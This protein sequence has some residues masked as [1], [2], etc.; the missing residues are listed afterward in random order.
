MGRQ[1]TR[2]QVSGYRFTMRR[3]EHALVRGDVRML[4][5]PIRAQ[6]ISLMTG[7]VLA[8][9]AIAVCGVLAVLRPQGAPGD[10]PILRARESGA[11]YV[12]IGD[13]VHPVPDLVS[14]RL[15]VGSAADP[16]TVAAAAIEKMPRGP[17]A[18]IVGAPA[19]VGAPLAAAQ[20]EWTVCDTASATTLLIGPPAGPAAGEDAA[21]LV[22]ARSEGPAT[23]FLMYGGRRAAVDL[24]DTAV[25]RAL[26]LDTVAPHPVSRALLDTVPE[27]PPIIAPP[28]AGAGR[29]GALPGRPVGTIIGVRR[30][31]GVE[32]YVVLAGGLQ[33]VGEVT[34][35]LI[36]F[37]V[38]Q[39]HADVPDVQ[40]D[41]LA[42]ADIVDSLP[43]ASYPDR[44]DVADAE[45]PCVRW[46]ARDGR[47][48]AALVDGR[49]TLA[50][51]GTVALAQADGAGPNVDA[52][53][54]PAG[55]S[56]YLRPVSATGAGGG[57]ESRMLLTDSG[58]LYAVPD[59]AT[60]RSLGIDDG[61][62]PGPWPVL[63]RL[64]RG[65][66]LSRESASVV[67]DAVPAARPAG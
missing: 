25:V 9:I 1:I 60:A 55:H 22:T 50:A 31:G 33:R 48:G 64:P 32:H 47:V 56:V 43:V 59:D 61:P 17:R 36:R 12:R 42:G 66:E 3:L 57:A 39:P 52:V 34:A 41:V 8:V 46:A 20:T 2:L 65:P 62:M 28:I 11:Y 54:V 7:C 24:R 14:A 4:D 15:I 67:R 30:G 21:L 44:V 19:T 6:S 26:R 10:A 27:S 23:T 18:G 51:P 16:K 29:P 58:V 38:A 53:R 49:Q 63:A 13:T 35:D 5:D 40:P 45:V 37:T